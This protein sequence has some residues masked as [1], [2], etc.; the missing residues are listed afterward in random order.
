MKNKFEAANVDATQCLKVVVD[1]IRGNKN[2]D[3]SIIDLS[4]LGL[5]EESALKVLNDTPR[6]NIVDI[7]NHLKIKL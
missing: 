6:D 3:Q 7:K 5:D 2:L 1:Y 4:K